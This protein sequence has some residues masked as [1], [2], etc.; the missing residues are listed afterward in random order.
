MRSSL[1]AVIGWWVFTFGLA[2]QINKTTLSNGTILLNGRPFPMVLDAGTDSFTPQDYAT[3]MGNKDAWGANTWWLQYS[4]RHMSSESEGD[5]SGLAN[6]LDFFEKTGVWVNLYIRGEYRD[7]P[8]WFSKTYS[9]YQ[10]L[11]PQGKP[12]G[13]Q[14]CLQHEGFRRLIDHYTRGIARAARNHPSLL[15]YGTYDEFCIRGWGCW[16]PRCIRKY[17]D[18]LKDKY[19]DIQ[20]LNRVWR[21]SYSSWDQIDAPRTQSFDANYGDWQRYRLQVLHD[22]GALYYRALKEEDPNHLVWIDINMDL[23]D[24]TWKRLCVW[25]KLTDI[26]DVFNQGPG[27]YADEAG[28]RTAM[29]RAIRDNYGKGAT[30]HRGIEEREFTYKPELYSLLFEGGHTGLVWWYDF[31]KVLRTDI[32]WGADDAET[33]SSANWSA[34]AELNHLAQYLGDLYVNSKPVRGQVAVFVSG[35]TDMMRSVT[36]KQALDRENPTNLEGLCQML[37][38]LNI[39]YEA[40]GE[41]Q[42][43]KLGTFRAVLIGQ[44][45]MCADEQTVKAFREYVRNGGMLVATNHA[46]SAD[47]NGKEIANPAFGLDNLWGSSGNA[48][49]AVEDGRV[50]PVAGN[51]LGIS[52]AL[53]FPTLGKVSRRKLASAQV[54]ARLADGTPAVTLNRYVNGSVLFIGT[55]AGEAYNYGSLLG[56]GRYRLPRGEKL[57]LSRYQELVKR[58]DGWRNY[59]PLMQAALSRAGIGSPVAITSPDNADLRNIARASLQEQ[60]GS[61]SGSLNHLLL[62]TLEPV[63]DPVAEIG[64][65]PQKPAKAQARSLRNLTIAVEVP[66][67]SAV[68]A[69]YRIPAI[70]NAIDQIDA[71]PEKIPFRVSGGKLRLEVYAISE[72]ACFLIARDA[73]PLVGVRSEKIG[74][75]EGQPTRVTVTVDNAGAK[76]ISGEITFPRGF[77]GVPLNGASPKFKNLPPAQRFSRTFDVYAPSPLEFNRTFRA[78]VTPEQEGGGRIAESYPVT[79]RLGERVAHGWLKRVEA[80][81]TEAATTDGTPHGDLY[82]EALQNRELVYA[83]YNNGDWAKVARLAKQGL[84]LFQQL[85]QARLRGHNEPDPE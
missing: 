30:W 40:I 71:V 26:F 63:Y 22:F 25:W 12:V 64:G 70:G 49:E 45:A 76:G 79:S 52:T 48:N 28:T 43:D 61:E 29:S 7:L 66:D 74:A 8:S 17:R 24:Y 16:C 33:P 10:M 4:M 18:F 60:R 41:D 57:D 37:R 51:A 3:V 62:V 21:A 27:S 46:F 82:A 44:F 56:M 84:S 85:K 23:Y 54:I 47:E 78:Q 81:M 36:D 53:Y 50:T 5:F 83:A 42:L 1:V 72:A 15:M 19:R 58:F 80:A 6:A 14:V 75:V 65:T 11:D 20:S 55:N 2:A 35:L 38:D 9:D 67:P 31:W 39:P 32:V 68:K 13:T 34:S 59:A 69:V 77:R 73:R